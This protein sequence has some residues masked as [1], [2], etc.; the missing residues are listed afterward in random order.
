MK[1]L[2]TLDRKRLVLLAPP[3]NFSY[4]RHMR[5]DFTDTLIEHGLADM[6]VLTT[7][8]NYSIEEIYAVTSEFIRR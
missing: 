3:L 7:T 6:T 1:K 5:D 4:Y 2:A 8:V